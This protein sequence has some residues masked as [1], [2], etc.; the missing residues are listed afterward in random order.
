MLWVLV[1]L[2]LATLVFTHYRDRSK[3]AEQRGRIIAKYAL[4][5]MRLDP[6]GQARFDRIADRF[7]EKM[8]WVGQDMEVAEEMKAMIGA[9]AAQLLVNLPDARL[10]HFNTVVLHKRHFRSARTR[11]IHLGETRPG[12]GEIVISWSDLVFGYSNSHDAEN[13]GLHELAH[14]L[15]FENLFLGERC[16]NWTDDLV[17]RWHT[18]AAPEIELIRAGRSTLFSSYA[19]TNEAEFF[20]VAVEFFFERGIEFKERLPEL[21]RCLCELLRQDPSTL[22]PAQRGPGVLSKSAV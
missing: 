19:G 6:D 12:A 21:H 7:V 11:R 18:L 2:V 17:R 1:L 20:A 14:A 10:P 3:A 13:V 16:A 9:C 22:P 4:F 8:E 15:W 5:R